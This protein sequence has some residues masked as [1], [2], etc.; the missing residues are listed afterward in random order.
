MVPKCEILQNMDLDVI[1]FLGYTPTYLHTLLLQNNLTWT[2]HTFLKRKRQG[3]EWKPSSQTL[4]TI[5]AYT[6]SDWLKRGL[7]RCRIHNLP[8]CSRQEVNYS[9]TAQTKNNHSYKHTKTKTVLNSLKNDKI[10]GRQ[11]YCGGDY[12]YFHNILIKHEI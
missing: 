7:M 9:R 5:R 1:F 4:V 6:W 3:R 2:Q 10:V 11:Q 8:S 12:W